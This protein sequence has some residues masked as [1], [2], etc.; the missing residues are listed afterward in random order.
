M[1][2]ELNASKDKFFAIIAHDLKG[3][4]QG[5]LGYSEI[6]SND[7]DN[8]SRTEITD[9]AHDLHDSA[10]HLFR[11][12]ENLLQWT[13]IQR[14][15]IECTP[16][17][18]SFGQLASMNIE[19]LLSNAKLKGVE[20]INQVPNDITIFADLNMVNTIIRNLLS[21]ALKFTKQGGLITVSYKNLN[22]KF[23]EFSISDKGVGIEEDD[24]KNLF[25]IDVHH[26]TLGTANEKGTGLGLILCKDLVE[27]NG[28][29]IR[30]E[31]TVNVGTTFYFTLPKGNSEDAG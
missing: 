9:F 1:L 23:Y 10:K 18:I 17:H 5:L 21:N 27:K 11:L 25:K 16:T 8:L 14:G 30:A 22:E 19:I 24:L 15:N 2:K 6:L 7:I 20:L 13:R 29:K 26:T 3:P 4:F 28:G 31:S 12:L